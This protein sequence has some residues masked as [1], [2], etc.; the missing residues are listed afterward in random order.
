M[1][2]RFATEGAVAAANHLAAFAGAATLTH[3]G[4]AVDAAI[5]AA[6]VMAVTAPEM[7]GLGGDLFAVVAKRRDAPVALN[8]SGRAGSGADPD[9]LRADGHRVMPYRHDV[10]TVT[11]PGCVDGLL[12]LHRRFG[13]LELA[14]LLAPAH[15]LAEAGFPV[16]ATLAAKSSE[17]PSELRVAVFAQRKPLK[18]AQRLRLPGLAHVLAGVASSG[19]AAFY[20][21]DVGRDLIALGRGEFAEE[22]L[23]TEQ[24]EWVPP[25]EIGAFG[26]RLWT[27][28]PNSQGYLALSGA[29]IAERAGFPHDADDERWAFALVEAARQ[30]AFDRIDVLHECAD[31]AALVAPDRLGPR[32]AAIADR[33]SAHLADPH[34]DGGTTCVCAVDR[35]RTGVSLIMSNAADFG[36]HLAL[37]THGIFL[38]NRGLGFSLEPG[39]AAEYGPRRRPPHTLVPLVV[40]GEDGVLERV[41]GTMGAD[42]QPQILLQ[43]LAR[44]LAGGQETGDA[45]EAP[46]WILAREGGDSF[47]VWGGDGPPVVRLE[48]RAP[49]AWAAGLRG[50]GYEVAESG[51][52]EH[53]FGHAQMIRVTEDGMLAGASDPRSGAGAIVGC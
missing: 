11:V 20:A 41:L 23:L 27:A 16:S 7:C 31:G 47:H 49:A 36:S 21:G 25:L 3:G 40:T 46:R 6:A 39:H 26:H 22:D 14:R 12:A 35:D 2:T 19:R 53:A 50:R 33:V 5:S 29:W 4:N 34:R 13:K 18:I 44:T 37:S 45:V 8:A 1:I 43:L 32:A 30:A 48:A 10:R 24:A 9:R 38:H 28:P 52:A 17:L 15:R 51:F 42:G